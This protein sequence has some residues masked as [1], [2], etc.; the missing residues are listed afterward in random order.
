MNYIFLKSGKAKNVFR[1]WGLFYLFG[2]QIEGLESV[3]FSVN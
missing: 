2:R 3:D 1:E